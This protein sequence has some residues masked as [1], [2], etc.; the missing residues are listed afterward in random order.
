[1]SFLLFCVFRVFRGLIFFSVW[2]DVASPM[3]QEHTM[4]TR[5]FLPL[6]AVALTLVVPLQADPLPEGARARFGTTDLWH[7]KMVITVAFS[8]DGK[9]LA[10]GGWDNLVRV[11]EVPSGKP[12]FK[13]EGHSAAVW[14]A[15]FSPDGKQ[16]LSTDQGGGVK[17]WDL[18]TRREV[19]SFEGHTGGVYKPAWADGGRTLITPSF[20]QSIR[21]WDVAT[22]KEKLSIATGAEVHGLA[23]SP[24]GKT[25]ASS[26]N[27]GK[28]SFWEP[29]SGKPIR[30][31]QGHENGID[32][33]EFSRDGTM[34]V[35]GGWDSKAV[36]WEA[37]TG[38]KVRELV[39]HRDNVWPVVIAPD[40]K[41]IAT[42]SRDG[43]IRLWDMMTG[44]ELRVLEGHQ[45]GIP[46]VAI[47]PDGKLLASASWD[48]H[49]RIWELATGKPVAPQQGHLGPVLDVHLSKDGVQAHSIGED[50]TL[51][52]WQTR[53]Q[54]E[55]A[56]KTLPAF[57]IAVFSGDGSRV[58]L[59]EETERAILLD[60][61]S[62]KELTRFG[63][64]GARSLLPVLSHTGHRLL[65]MTSET[66]L[67]VWNLPDSKMVFQHSFEG[68]VITAVALTPDGSHLAVGT[69][70]GWIYVWRIDNKLELRRMM[71][72]AAPA[73]LAFSPDGRMLA[74]AAPGNSVRVWE[75]L[76]GE[77][78]V[79]LASE[80]PNASSLVFSPTGQLLAVGDPAG[81]IEAWDLSVAGKPVKVNGHVAKIGALHFSRDDQSLVSGGDDSVVLIW[82]LAK[83]G[84]PSKK[85][86]KPTGK[87]L[88]SAWRDLSLPDAKKAFQAIR[89]LQLD[90]EASFDLIAG[91]LKPEPAIDA[92][93]IARLVKQLDDD[94]FAEREKASAELRKLAPRAEPELRKAFA[95]ATSVEVRRRLTEILTGLA[96]TPATPASLQ[97][98]RAVE[99]LEKI[100]P[101]S[102]PMLE[103][104][105]KGAENSDLTRSAQ[106]ALKRLHSTE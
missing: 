19:R 31:W 71:P 17:L 44:K 70:D 93:R 101:S 88:E 63:R 66:S 57:K 27:N 8:P 11:W 9:Q 49:A 72:G 23:L 15:I 53:E 50:R 74:E 83:V 38:K 22:G 33:L 62:G 39:G 29:G 20:D 43:T 99:V 47:S 7:G 68:S 35:S 14:R 46:M 80:C 105:A 16:L 89:L 69:S 59:V 12:L 52:T 106:E 25:L 21:I 75:V 100:G 67:R 98:L 48:G 32:H 64:V 56:Q 79:E 2:S 85:P 87:E 42:G 103:K 61:Q 6:L 82:D 41:T 86:E 58:L 1:V 92:A 84:L 4:S 60:V 45:K 97:S 102:R 26:D 73:R 34:L 91:E 78:R 81:V 76:T 40:G 95:E 24:D 36:V 37:A 30:D 65:G 28:I 77:A 96:D 18:K 10:T 3:N 90:P 94:N 5:S 51:R 104:L 54:K 13:L 55:L